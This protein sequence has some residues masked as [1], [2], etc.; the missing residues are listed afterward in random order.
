MTMLRSAVLLRARIAVFLTAIT[1]ILPG[2]LSAAPA[3]PSGHTPT[4][5]SAVSRRPAPVPESRPASSASSHAASSE[6]ADAF[7]TANPAPGDLRLSKEEERK[8]E[9]LARFAQ[10]LLLEDAAENDAALEGFRRAFEL[11]PTNSDL[12]VKLAYMLAQRNDATGGIEVLKDA[13]KAAPKE[14]LPL[15]YLSQLYAKY[16]KKP[17]AGIK[18]AEQALAVDATSFAPYL[19]LFELLAATNQPTRIDQLLQRALRAPSTSA[20]F[21][22]QIGGLFQQAYMKEDGAVISPEAL[23]QM[24]ALFRKAATL[25]EDD[26]AVLARVGDYFIVSKQIADAIPF[27]LKAMSQKPAADGGH[28]LAEVGEKLFH[29]YDD[30]GEREKAIAVLEKI[31]TE[32][33]LRFEAFEKLGELYEKIGDTDKALTNYKHSLLLDASEP[34]NHIRVFYLELAKKRYDDAVETA[35]SAREHFPDNPVTIQLLA[36]A[37][38]QAK[39]H[40]DAMTA[41]AQALNEYENGHEE[42]L[43]SR[44]YFTYGAAAEQAGLPTKAE[45]LLK[46]SLELDPS[47][48]GSAQTYNYLGYMWADRGENLEEA[49]EMIKKAVAMDPDNG[50]YLDSLGWFFFKKGEFDK[51]LAQLVRASELSKAD[52]DPTVMEHLGDTYQKLGKA[53]Q[54]L[55]YWQKSLALDPE[56]KKIAEKIETA[57]EKVSSNTAKPDLVVPAP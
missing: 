34:Q 3:A 54:A 16:L 51:A 17:E 22:L 7:P 55:Q 15:V 46:K 21:W 32:N 48:P 31:T 29:A 1:C 19:A 44:F 6:F 56:N 50:A 26:P 20:Q 27:Y 36:I 11:D 18:Y 41:F 8:A 5:K 25:G 24:N 35:R 10:A 47:G 33:P 42:M 39:K 40:E 4:E 43:D 23:K 2:R 28:L 13:V 9:A 37:L 38:S 12:A 53:A 52:A 49:G 30:V 14:P 45:E 57:K